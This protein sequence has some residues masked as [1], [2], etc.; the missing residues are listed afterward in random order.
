MI[1][2][3]QPNTDIIVSVDY[4]IDG[5]APV[6]P[7]RVE[8]EV[9]DQDGAVLIARRD[10]VSGEL[11]DN[12][13]SV[14]VGNAH[15]DLAGALRVMRSVRAYFTKASGAILPATVRYVVEAADRL[16]VMTNSFQTLDQ[17]ALT[18]MEMPA[19]DGWD[20]AAEGE[21]IGAMVT[22]FDAICRMTFKYRV[23]QEAME[24]DSV[25]VDEFGLY[26]YVTDMR[27]RDMDDWNS[28]PADFRK[29]MQRAQLYEANTKLAGDPIGDKRALGIVSESVGESKMFF[30]NK[31]PLRHPVGMDALNVLAPYIHRN[32]RIGRG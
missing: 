17:A 5:T 1:P 8:Y 19:L 14:E 21:Q 12:V 26:R 10:A 7:T 11:A 18:R 4:P 23:S 29:A 15:N 27:L 24:W 20:M 32:N 13:L 9:L 31:A 16:I 22:A 30:S 2:S 25:A 6:V 3:Y 28:F